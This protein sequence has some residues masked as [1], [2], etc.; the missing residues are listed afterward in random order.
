MSIIEIGENQIKSVI[1]INKLVSIYKSILC[2]KEQH[3][4]NNPA[5]VIAE[6]HSSQFSFTSGEILN[7]LYHISGYRSYHK[8]KKGERV[9]NDIFYICDHHQKNRQKIVSSKYIREWRVAAIAITICH[10]MLGKSIEHIALIGEG[11]IGSRCLETF[12]DFFD[13]QS[14]NILKHKYRELPRDKAQ[15]QDKIPT[16]YRSSIGET[17]SN[18]DIIITAT[19]STTPIIF[20]KHLKKSYFLINIGP[21]YMNNNELSSDVYEKSD[22]II[23][24]SIAQLTAKKNNFIFKDHLSKIKD[25]TQ[26]KSIVDTRKKRIVFASLGAASTDIMLAYLLLKEIENE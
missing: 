13:I 17:I 19:N 14:I 5:R 4:K 1:D 10:L 12:C 8:T 3:Q 25:F 21:K 24:D 7:D 26:V 20:N 9:G 15:Y 2:D 23:T 18:A 22:F 6:T 11:A 16:T